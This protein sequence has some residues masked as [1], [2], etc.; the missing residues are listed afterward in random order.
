MQLRIACWMFANGTCATGEPTTIAPKEIIAVYAGGRDSVRRASAVNT[1]E[2]QRNGTDKWWKFNLISFHNFSAF[3]SQWQRCCGATPASARCSMALF[4][5]Q[6]DRIDLVY[7]A[8]LCTRQA[9]VYCICA[10]PKTTIAGKQWQATAP[11]FD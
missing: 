10:R 6:T 4:V 5:R 2:T 11:T 3:S 7:A 8:W 9:R 1:A